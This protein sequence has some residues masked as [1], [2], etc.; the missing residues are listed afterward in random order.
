MKAKKPLG[1]SLNNV[2]MNS[3]KIRVKWVQFEKRS[4]ILSLKEPVLE[5]VIKK[6]IKSC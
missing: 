6:E 5:D 1:H 3:Y 2:A 4:F